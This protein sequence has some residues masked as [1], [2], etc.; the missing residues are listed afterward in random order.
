MNPASRPTPRV[1]GRADAGDLCQRCKDPHTIGATLDHVVEETLYVV[2][3]DAGS[4]AGKVRKE[5]YAKAQASRDP[6]IRSAYRGWPSPSSSIEIILKAVLL[7][8]STGGSA[9]L[10]R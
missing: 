8:A 5:A 1:D 7:Y 10:D 9:L 4:V 3:R 2:D 6:A